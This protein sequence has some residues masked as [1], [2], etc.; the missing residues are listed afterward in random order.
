MTQYDEGALQEAVA[1][2]GPVSIG[3]DAS[4]ISFQ[5][6]SSGEPLFLFQIEVQM[7]FAFR[8]WSLSSLSLGAFL[9]VYDEP[10]CSSTELDHGVLAVGYGSDNGKDYWLVKNRSFFL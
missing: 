7:G 8:P 5:L 2:I 9:G 4:Q 1:T 10:S 3:I 6:Y